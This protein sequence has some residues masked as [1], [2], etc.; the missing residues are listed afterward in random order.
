MLNQFGMSRVMEPKGAVPV[1]AW[2][3]NDAREISEGEARIKL[4]IV[5][6]ERDSFQQICQEA[7]FDDVKIMARIAELVERR[8]KLHNPFTNSGGMCVGTIEEMGEGFAKKHRAINVG[9]E[10]ICATTLAGVPMH[11]DEINGIDFN[12]GSI[13]IEGYAIVFES[14]PVYI[15]PEGLPINYTM[16]AIDEAATFSTINKR[17]V[18]G[19]SIMIIARDLVS[20]MIY[21][22]SI[23]HSL[24]EEGAIIVVMDS[25]NLGKVTEKEAEEVLSCYKVKLLIT[26][27]TQPI[28]AFH[29]INKQTDR[30]VDATINTEDLTGSETLAVLVTAPGGYIFFTSLQNGY[31]TAVL[32]AETMMKELKMYSFDQYSD[33]YY[34]YTVACLRMMKPELDKLN[35]LYERV[36]QAEAMTEKQTQDILRKKA[37][38]IGDFVFQSPVTGAMVDD[39]LNIANYDCNAIIQGETGVGK[40]KILSLIHNN[41]SRKNNPCIKINCA[42]IQENLAESEF[43]GYEAGAFT[44]AQATGKKGYFEMANKG[45]LFLDEIGQLSLNM[46]SKLLR[47]LQENQFY[48]IGGT[49]QLTVNVRVICANNI[50]LR[51]L[52]DEGK[53]REDLYYRLNICTIEV[54]PLRDRREDIYILAENFLNRYSKKYGVEKDISPDGMSQ[55]YHYGWPGNV[56]ELENVIHRMIIGT[57]GNIIDYESVERVLNEKIYDDVV[58][59]IKQYLKTKEEFSFGEIIKEQEKRLI[60]YA[61]KREGSTR[62]AATFLNMTQAQLARKKLKYDL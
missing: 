51:K 60:Q 48:R 45:I 47:V 28:E 11:I 50:P 25:E 44:G 32:V 46:Q 40:E 55:L 38:K 36:E 41:S 37:G 49:Q 13:Q 54:P 23:R 8:G 3:L 5:Q 20:A 19:M 30:R 17:M 58:F 9:D 59:D 4:Q 7:G 39:V 33:G 52:V 6:L 43:F 15:R 14:S 53:F 12:Y 22:G 57:K 18:K 21:A 34:D 61:L 42:T 27:V 56:R 1:T 26:D 62:K 31:G 16:I 29:Y 10:I 24:G 2:K 35:E